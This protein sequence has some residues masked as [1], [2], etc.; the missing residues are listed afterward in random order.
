[1]K[2]KRDSGLD[3]SAN[4]IL[5]TNGGKHAVA[6]TFMTLLNPGDEVLIPAPVL[7][8]VSRSGL[9]RRWRGRAGDDRATRTA[10][11]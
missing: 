10:F 11:A 3:V 8:D 1:M 2:S 7:D 6:T 9:S 4:Q 5:V